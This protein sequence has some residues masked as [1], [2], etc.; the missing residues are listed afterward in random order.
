MEYQTVQQT[1]RQLADDEALWIFGYGSLI[2]RV[3][4]PYAES[5]PAYIEGYVR[6]FWQGSTDHRGVPGA[7][8]RVVTLVEQP[9]ATCWGMAYRIAAEQRDTVLAHLDYREKGGYQ[10]TRLT[11]YLKDRPAVMGITYH[12]TE[13]NENFLGAADH[14]AIA[15]QIM[16]SRGPSGHNVEYALRLHEALTELDAHDPHVHEIARHIQQLSYGTQASE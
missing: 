14:L 1:R 4:F 15:R 11:L 13:Y 10:R 5:R 6:R 16:T 8:G 2:W 9:G 12:A 3:D 7:P